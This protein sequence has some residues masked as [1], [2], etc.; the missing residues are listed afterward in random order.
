MYRGCDRKTGALLA[1]LFICAVT[2]CG[3]AAGDELPKLTLRGAH[4]TEA[5]A[6]FE[7]KWFVFFGLVNAYPKLESEK[8]VDKYFNPAMRLLAPGF[9][10]VRTI[11]DLRDDHLI[12][13]PTIGVGRTLTKRWAIL[14][15]GGYSAG[16]VR[17]KAVDASWLL[18]PLATDFEIYRSALYV[19]IGLDYFPFGMPIQKDYAGW[20]ERLRAARPALGVR[21]TLTHASFK[22]KIKVGFRP[23]GNLVNLEL[24][25]SWTLP[26]INTNVGLDIP[27]SKRNTISLNAG[28]NF[29]FDEKE[30]FEGTAFTITWKH[31]LK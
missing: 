11:S 31:F 15:Q 17:T 25:D 27:L 4:I 29:F 6:V 30:D 7:R 18:F 12:W 28:V 24:R 9:D 10:D 20:G 14:M 2:R 22:A 8:L 26:S 3:V 13:P 21:V 5:D 16:K 1:A 23:L 19:G